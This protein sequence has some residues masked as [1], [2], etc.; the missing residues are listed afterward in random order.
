MVAD[1]PHIATHL[2]AVLAF[3]SIQAVLVAIFRIL[4]GPNNVTLPPVQRE[5]ALSY[6]RVITLTA[7]ALYLGGGAMRDIVVVAAG[8]ESWG[9]WPVLWSGVS[10]IIQ[11]SAACLFIWNISRAVCGNWL[12]TLSLAVAVAVSLMVAG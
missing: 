4:R 9:A 7:F 2:S 6:A 8:V 12:W 11:L 10:R 5:I 3:L 1:W